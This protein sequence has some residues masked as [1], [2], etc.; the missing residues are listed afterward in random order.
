MSIVCLPWVCRLYCLLALGESRLLF[1]YLGLVVSSVVCIWSV[2][3]LEHT[4]LHTNLWKIRENPVV[5]AW[6]GLPVTVM[7]PTCCSPAS[8][9]V[10]G[11]HV[12]CPEEKSGSCLEWTKV[13]FT[14]FHSLL[15]AGNQYTNTWAGWCYYGVA[16]I[17]NSGLF[18]I[19]WDGTSG[20]SI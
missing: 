2:T 16:A 9:L 1:V 17:M 8:K 15:D 11:V 14:L 18:F 19:T 20:L 7:T 4:K 5:H 13:R 10:T 12:H 6:Q 3:E